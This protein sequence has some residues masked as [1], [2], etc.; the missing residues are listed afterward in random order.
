ML[1]VRW[2]TPPARS[3]RPTEPA[4]NSGAG[5]GQPTMSWADHLTRNVETSWQD[6]ESR[7]DHETLKRSNDARTT[8]AFPP[9]R[10]S[11]RPG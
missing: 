10:D 8:L 7:S 1:L 9:K 6:G 5:H 2:D 4:N 3:S 11:R